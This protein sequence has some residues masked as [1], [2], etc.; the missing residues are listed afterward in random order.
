MIRLREAKLA[1]LS[2]SEVTPCAWTVEH[3]HLQAL[4]QPR[5][6]PSPYPQACTPATPPFHAPPQA[7]AKPVK[8]KSDLYLSGY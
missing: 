6:T 1:S 8:P 3:P 4:D 5:Y 7:L 2:S